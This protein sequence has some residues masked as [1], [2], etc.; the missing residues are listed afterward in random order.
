[1]KVRLG[2]WDASSATEPITALEFLVARIFINPNFNSANVRNSIAILRLT[3]AVPLGQTPTITTGC[4]PSAQI[5]GMRCYT[6]G[7]GKND[8][9][10]GIYQ[11]IIKEVDVPIV[12]STVCQNLLRSTRLGANFQLDTNSFMCAGGEAG[13]DVRII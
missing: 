13:K 11:S 1:M 4:L 6:A 3:S 7:W 2:E 9:V 8:F 12:D 5:S 10:N